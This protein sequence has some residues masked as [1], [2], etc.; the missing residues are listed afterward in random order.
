M[1]ATWCRQVDCTFNIWLQRTHISY[2]LEAEVREAILK[3]SQPE[4]LLYI[5]VDSVHCE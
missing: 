1:L 5:F 2:V 3:V 4:W